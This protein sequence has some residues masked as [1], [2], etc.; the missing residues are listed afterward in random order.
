VIG[1]RNSDGIT[2]FVATELL[3]WMEVPVVVFKLISA[4]LSWIGDGMMQRKEKIKLT[5]IL[6]ENEIDVMG[7]IGNEKVRLR[8]IEKYLRLTGTVKQP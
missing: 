8:G 4:S 2:T 3:L 1:Q 7:N 6:C 5:L